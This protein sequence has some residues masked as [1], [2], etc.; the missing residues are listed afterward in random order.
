MPNSPPPTPTITLSFT[1]SGAIVI[2]YAS[3]TSATAMFQS[4]WPFFASIAM[5]CASSVPMN[6]VSPRIATPRLLAPQ[7]TR[8][9]GAGVYRYCQNTRPV[10][11]STAMTSLGR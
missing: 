4:G 5:R 3:F 9:S 1:T 8:A 2:E 6:S 11:A 7:Q 10:L